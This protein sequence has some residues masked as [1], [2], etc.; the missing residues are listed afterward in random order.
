M[1]APPESRP[2]AGLAAAAAAVLAATVAVSVSAPSLAR[3]LLPALA[4]LVL[5]PALLGVL[6]GGLFGL[7]LRGRH[8]VAA[9][10]GALLAAAPW[11]GVAAAPIARLPLMGWIGA[12][13]AVLLG[14][15]LSAAGRRRAVAVVLGVLVVAARPAPQIEPDASAVQPVVVVGIDAGTWPQIDPMIAA[16]ELPHLAAL[17]V[18]GASGTLKSEEPSLSPRVW[19]IMATGQPTEVNGVIDFNSDRQNLRVGRFWDAAVEAGS[20]VGLM[21]WHITWPPDDYPGFGVPG[22]L[23]RGYEALPA[24]ASFLKR[25]EASGKARAPLLSGRMFGDGLSA[26]AISAADSAWLNLRAMGEIVLR[27]LGEEDRYWRIKMVQAR[28]Q[29]DLWFELMLREAP[30]CSALILYPVD[31]LGH[32]Y[33]KYHEP[34]AFGE[35]AFEGVS[36][37]L[38]AERA[39]V[40][41]DAY[42]ESD[43]HL[44]R[45]L[46]RLDLDRVLVA[47]VSD[48]G[49]KAASEGGHLTGRVR[50]QALFE[51]LGVADR[52]NYSVAGKQLNISSSVGGEAGRQDLLE[53]HRMLSESHVAGK[54]EA[55]PFLPQPFR[56]EVGLVVVDYAPGVLDGFDTPLLVAGQEVT[57]GDL[58]RTEDRSGDHT[59]DGIVLLRGPGILPGARIGEGGDEVADL[60]DVAPTLLHAMGL[61]V[62]ADLPGRVLTEAFDPAALAERP[63]R[64]VPGGLPDPPEPRMPSD[65]TA[66]EAAD[67]NLQDLGYVDSDDE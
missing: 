34:E 7:V 24:E 26:M 3:P 48:H 35:E 37:A 45:V 32:N 43:R 52:V 23:A 47:V 61:P 67:Q 19:T 63:V 17:R 18:E 5:A 28:L 21:E 22:W 33:W 14:V 25:L 42:R 57:A 49:M 44:G 62:P 10:L 2:S 36:P 29:T 8:A 56:E 20:G 12:L 39:E 51:L 46:E 6:L 11:L 41:R 1:T 31:S 66:A 50:A 54:P 38:R 58:F 53:V 16:G 65:P 4:L 55:R 59:L 15:W 13:L 9:A 27:G 40:V 60:Y 30:G 64:T